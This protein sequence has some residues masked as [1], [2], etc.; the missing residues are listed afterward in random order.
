MGSPG[1]GIPEEK[2]MSGRRRGGKR[3]RYYGP[4]PSDSWS[5]EKT[6]EKPIR[7]K[8]CSLRKRSLRRFFGKEER[9]SHKRLVYWGKED[10]GA[11]GPS[12]QC[13]D[14]AVPTKKE[15][16]MRGSELI[17]R[18]SGRR[19]FP[20]FNTSKIP[21][22][23]R[24][25]LKGVRAERGPTF[26]EV[27]LVL[28]DHR[29]G[30]GS[31]EGVAQPPLGNRHD[32]GGKWGGRARRRRALLGVRILVFLGG[33]LRNLLAI[34]GIAHTRRINDLNKGVGLGKEG[35]RSRCRKPITYMEGHRIPVRKE[36]LIAP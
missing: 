35:P 25:L 19:N 26:K 24:R 21:V 34:G 15:G 16:A 13:G 3:P 6:W 2:R 12:S 28:S 20:L 36:G 11:G 18:D 29:E 1:S 4:A 10:Q 33:A 30:S 23:G 31:K 5:E 7:G 22:P 14:A 27:P 9:A 8:E 17:F 32:Q